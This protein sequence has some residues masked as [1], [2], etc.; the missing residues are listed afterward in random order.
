M[1]ILENNYEGEMKDGKKHGK[2]KMDF[3]IGVKYTGD[4]LNDAIT[5]EGI[6]S[7]VNGD[8]YELR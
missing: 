7:F 6:C 8:H 5:G 3:A 1:T 2:G 4:W